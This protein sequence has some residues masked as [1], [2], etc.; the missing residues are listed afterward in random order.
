MQQTQRMQEMRNCVKTLQANVQDKTSNHTHSDHFLLNARTRATCMVTFLSSDEGKQKEQPQNFSCLQLYHILTGK[1][2]ANTCWS[3]WLPPLFCFVVL[4]KMEKQSVWLVTSTK[5]HQ[6]CRIY[7]DGVYILWTLKFEG[8]L[9]ELL[10]PATV[11][12]I[13]R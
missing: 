9:E 11:N 4:T 13:L 1:K 12:R 10:E 2:K 7:R 8:E 6:P 3:R 5:I